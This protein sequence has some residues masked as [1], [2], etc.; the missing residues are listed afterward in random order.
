MNRYRLFFS[1]V[2]VT[3]GILW[4]AGCNRGIDE[5]AQ[6]RQR[7]LEKADAVDTDQVR[8]AIE[9]V[10]SSSELDQV[11]AQQ[12]IR[13]L[14]NA[15]VDSR[16]MEGAWS[17]PQI[18]STLDS[19]LASFPTVKTMDSTRYDERDTEYLRLNFLLKKLVTWIGESAWQDPLFVDWLEM[20][21]E[22]LGPD[23]RDTL[24]RATR[25]FDWTMRNISL[26]RLAAE[27]PAPP[28]P[29]LPVGLIYRG[30]GYRQT[31]FQTLFRGSGDSRQRARVFIQLCRQAGI[32]ACMLGVL[33]DESKD[34]EEWAV[35]VLLGKEIFLFDSELGIPI[36]G[37]GQIGIAT[38]EEARKD[39]T[40][41]R[42]LNVPGWFEYGTD[43]KQVQQ[44]IA[45][46]D[47][48]PES[49]ARRMQHLEGSL[50]GDNRMVL[51]YDADAIA[52]AWDAVS[53]VAGARLWKLSVQSQAYEAALQFE[54]QSN[55]MLAAFEASQ[56]GMLNGSFPLP[57]ARWKHLEGKFND[58]DDQQGAR[59]LYMQLLSPEDDIN[60]LR[61]D[62]DLQNAYSFR[63]EL[64][65]SQA[66]FDQRIQQVQ[67][68][69]RTSKRTATYWISLIHYDT[70]AF[71]TAE[72]WFDK[73]ALNEE[74]DS[75]WKPAARYN[76]ARTLEQLKDVKRAIELY[77]TNGDPQEH[78]NRIRARLL[79]R[80]TGE[81]TDEE[82][83]PADTAE[84]ER[85]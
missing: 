13:G 1:A 21:G 45:L 55:A 35:G 80:Q 51:Y 65:S 60:R 42:R 31:P 30:P 50:V 7:R 63:R 20:Q 61:T 72:K 37:P 57:R 84:V 12:R 15:W 26:E 66:E 8:E 77:K 78:G 52:E 4:F 43:S 3:V 81:E 34:P 40:V 39:S 67:Q 22:R 47:A 73:R 44:T 71:D 28:A 83:E 19:D 54:M 85:P 29:D 74:R 70:S 68:F 64:G 59:V 38:L 48:P 16:P 69:M 49:L 46:L 32:E 79:Q 25:L 56:W 58:V 62:V 41:L 2:G 76:L 5:V 33:S 18:L 24:I 11:S 23:G 17:K 36:P 14:L 9:F 53:G 75:M 10:A 27:G 6:I 82:R